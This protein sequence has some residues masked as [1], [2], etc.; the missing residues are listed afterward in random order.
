[1]KMGRITI[2]MV[3][4]YAL[5]EINS[6]EVE[7]ISNNI[8][9]HLIKFKD[10]KIFDKN[11]YI[12]YYYNLDRII[13]K[14]NQ[15]SNAHKFLFEAVDMNSKFYTKYHL[16]LYKHVPY[17]ELLE[18]NIKLLNSKL[19]N[20][21]SHRREKRGL[22]NGLGS[23]IK[24]V[25][26]TMDDNDRQHYNSILNQLTKDQRVIQSQNN[27]ILKTHH[28]LVDKFNEQ[29]DKIN[30]NEENLKARLEILESKVN[31]NLETQLLHVVTQLTLV[32][33]SLLFLTESIET[34]LT[35]CNL[36]ILHESMISLEEITKLFK[37]YKIDLKVNDF[38][39]AVLFIK[40]LCKL[41]NNL[42]DIV[43][44]I[45]SYK[46]SNAEILQFTP[47]PIRIQNIPYILNE[48][49]QNILYDES[50]Y[51]VE[52]C[53]NLNEQYFCKIKNIKTDDCLTNL[54]I[55][56]NHS[57]CELN[58]LKYYPKFVMIPNSK[59]IIINV[60]NNNQV[61]IRCTNI[62][63]YLDNGLY[64]VIN[65]NCSVDN[66]PVISVFKTH[67]EIA[68]PRLSEK[69][70]INPVLNKKKEIKVL[71]LNKIELKDNAPEQISNENRHY[72]SLSIILSSVC[73]VLIIICICIF[74][75]CY[76]D[77]FKKFLYNIKR[78][79]N[80][81]CEEDNTINDF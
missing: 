1:M 8:G 44:E 4:I 36:H 56:Q 37:F 73:L 30:I 5:L 78:A 13:E 39:E 55:N 49:F 46:N 16:T 41:H 53:V 58:L 71:S 54:I 74:I 80:N 17:F 69:Y 34:S 3:L 12:H 15:I 76:F 70:N 32:T 21:L 62:N 11:H 27:L 38:W 40:P 68:L 24:V 10:V 20:L 65:D 33:N 43:L 35:F 31:E 77:R 66:D 79:N 45:P 72:S 23:L 9:F 63:R 47:L 60:E 26:G 2:W 22:I 25:T 18:Y 59:V 29:I 14:K 75:A 81:V 51:P 61:L 6:E 28:E 64:R 52:S 42:I 7:N 48:T 50:L 19:N 57:K 67:S